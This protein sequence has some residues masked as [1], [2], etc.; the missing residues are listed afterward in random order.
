V[1]NTRAPKLPALKD[2]PALMVVSPVRPQPSTALPGAVLFCAHAGSSMNPTLNELDVLEIV[3]YGNEPVRVGDVILFPAPERNRCVVHRVVSATPAGIS[4]RGDNSTGNDSWLLGPS[5]V[6]GRVVAAWHGLKRRGVAGGRL[7][8]LLAYRLHISSVLRRDLSL[9]LRPLYRSLAH[10]G[11]LRSLLPRRFRP[12]A[13]VFQTRGR[14]RLR[15]LMGKH[16]V[17]RYDARRHQWHIK[18]PFRL[19]VQEAALPAGPVGFGGESFR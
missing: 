13:V 15:L 10:W 2:D 19:F 3:P 1:S 9:F 11:R 14:P 5:D 4:T 18:P 12:R 7:G 17:G 6:S 8:W 16:V